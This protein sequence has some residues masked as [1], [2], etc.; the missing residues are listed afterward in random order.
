MPSLCLTFLRSMPTRRSL[1]GLKSLRHR[2][3][4][5][6]FVRF[7]GDRPPKL[8]YISFEILIRPINVA[9]RS[10]ELPKIPGVTE[11]SKKKI[12]TPEVRGRGNDRHSDT[13]I[14]E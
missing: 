12:R 6:S 13:V 7:R 10:F 1:R 3:Y 5:A 2:L 8:A 11:E 14:M 4:D 9:D